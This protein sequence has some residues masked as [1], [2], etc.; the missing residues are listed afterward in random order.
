MLWRGFRHCVPG[1][2]EIKVTLV[3]NEGANCAAA[4]VHFYQ[5]TQIM[6]RQNRYRRCNRLKDG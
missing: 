4:G 6:N 3:Q 1:I 2:P 5:L